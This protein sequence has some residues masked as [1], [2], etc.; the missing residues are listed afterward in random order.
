MAEHHIGHETHGKNKVDVCPKSMIFTAIEMAIEM[1]IQE[2]RNG[3]SKA[4]WDY[5]TFCDV[6]FPRIVNDIAEV[7]M[8]NSRVLGP[9]T[10]LRLGF[11]SS[12][13]KMGGHFGPTRLISFVAKPSLGGDKTLRHISLSAKPSM[14]ASFTG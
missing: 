11:S 8:H 5:D 3:F 12:H 13:P 14:I 4:V 6:F 2:R 1:A 9:P 10:S 7:I